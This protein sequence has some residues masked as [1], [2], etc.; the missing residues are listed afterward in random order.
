M[1]VKRSGVVLILGMLLCSSLI[2]MWSW[3]QQPKIRGLL[4]A[5]G[6]KIL[7]V[8]NEEVI[9][10]GITCRGLFG[11]WH[12]GCEPTYPNADHVRIVRE[13]GLNIIRIDFSLDMAVYGQE[14]GTPTSI[15]YRPEFWALLDQIVDAGE[16]YGIWIEFNFSPVNWATLWNGAGFPPWMYDGTWEYGTYYDA[17]PTGMA[18]AIR[19]FFN[20]DNPDQDGIRQTYVTF[21]RDIAARYRTRSYI[22]FCL[23]NEPLNT[24]GT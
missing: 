21:W 10:N 17:T 12:Y 7:N 5:D 19:E 4:H 23:F 6:T 20:T 13:H 24:G 8:A 15:N 9:W 2:V 1:K 3:S 18:W 22:V 14:P 11:Y 16:K